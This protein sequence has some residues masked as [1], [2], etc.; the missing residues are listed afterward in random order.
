MA[1]VRLTPG[2]T[3]GSFRLLGW[4]P[5]ASILMLA[6]SSCQDAQRRAFGPLKRSSDAIGD[7]G[8]I[9]SLSPSMSLG[10][11]AAPVKDIQQRATNIEEVLCHTPIPAGLLPVI[12][13]GAP[14]QVLPRLAC[15]AS[16]RWRR[17]GHLCPKSGRQWEGSWWHFWGA[18]TSKK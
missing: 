17:R 10:H 7:I 2:P 15:Q 1:L 12:R 13:H 11:L 4:Y 8:V 5:A 16:Q 18:P 9:A 14:M 6:P 3:L